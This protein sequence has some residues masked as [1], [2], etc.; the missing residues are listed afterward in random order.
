MAIVA[1]YLIITLI[2]SF[3]TLPNTYLN[4]NDVSFASKASILEQN[5]KD[6]DIDVKGRD[7][8]ELNFKSSDI[9]YIATIPQGASIDQ[10]PFSWPIAFLSG[11]KNDLTFDYKISYDEG[12]LDSLINESRL[13]T[14]I[15]EPKNAKIVYKDGEFSVEKE[16]VGNKIN[17][18]KIKEEILKCLF[19]RQSEL[20]LDD[21]AYYKPEIL[22]EDESVQKELESANEVA[23]LFYT[24]N[25]NGYDKKLDGETLISM[26][27]DQDGKF[28]LNDEKIKDY[29]QTIANETDTYGKERTFN[30]TDVGEI[31][32]NPG[33]YGYKLDVDATVKDIKEL[34]DKRESGEIE[35][36]YSH[37][38]YKRYSDGSDLKDTYVEVDLSRQYMWYYKG[39]KLI[40]SSALVS[41]DIS[42]DGVTNVGVGAIQSLVGKSTLKGE[43]W[44]GSEYN[45]PVNY[46]IPIGWDGEGFHDASW[47]SNFGGN[48]YITYGSHG[49]INLPPEIAKQLFETVETN[50]PVVVYESSTNYS[51]PMT[52]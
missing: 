49:C 25:I 22:S 3:I 15:T 29:V 30:A 9:N 47:R 20:V 46:W 44:D 18:D 34:V 26:F 45:T 27:E 16:I 33:V 38:G 42:K 24:F 52:Y 5:A 31:T 28:V 19:A 2:F 23:N 8:R 41:G 32:V 6:F 1:V 39:G 17:F 51:V 50:T 7:D 37:F 21:S 40:L 35:P 12:K 43:D 4:G 10:N 13:M 11:K 36:S 48:I 14:D